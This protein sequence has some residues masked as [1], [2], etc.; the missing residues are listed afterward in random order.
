MK[1]AV[2]VAPG[3][4]IGAGVPIMFKVELVLRMWLLLEETRE[5]HSRSPRSMLKL[6]EQCVDGLE[7]MRESAPVT[8]E[9]RCRACGCTESRACAGGCYW[10]VPGLCSRCAERLQAEKDKNRQ[11]RRD[12]EFERVHARNQTHRAKRSRGA[13]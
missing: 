11:Q 3:M 1:R 7:K 5:K 12:A 9:P 4:K 6:A 10:V 13:R 2:K 8:A